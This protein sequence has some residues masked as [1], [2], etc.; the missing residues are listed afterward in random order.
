MSIAEK[1]LGF[2]E[3]VD[4]HC[5]KGFQGFAARDCEKRKAGRHIIRSFH[6][7]C[8][9]WKEKTYPIEFLVISVE[10]KKDIDSDHFR[11]CLLNWNRQ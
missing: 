8:V 2:Q 1:D 9:A 6:S 10:R 4:L 5:G 3:F 7:P 11:V